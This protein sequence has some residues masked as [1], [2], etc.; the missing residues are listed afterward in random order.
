MVL[1]FRAQCAP[2]TIANHSRLVPFFNLMIARGANIDRLFVLAF[3]PAYMLPS[4]FV[5]R[6]ALEARH[7]ENPLV[8][9]LVG[10]QH[11]TGRLVDRR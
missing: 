7:L 11:M 5:E 10:S 1:D 6:T 2:C 8:R 4:D 9:L 3:G